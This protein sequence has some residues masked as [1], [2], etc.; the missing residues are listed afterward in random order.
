MTTDTPSAAPAPQRLSPRDEA[1]LAFA[2][3]A[4]LL[5]A[6]ADR[7]IPVRPF[8][9]GDLLRQ[10]LDLVRRAERL[11]E[12][13]V[14][15]EREA[16]T[17]WEQI[18]GVTG[19]TRQAAHERWTADLHAWAT[20]GRAAFPHTADA[21]LRHAEDLDRAYAQRHPDEPRAVT[22][23]L[24]SIRF[25]SHQASEESLRARGAA[26]HAR[27]AELRR[28][29]RDAAP[30]YDRLKHAS[31][32][33]GLLQLAANREDAAAREEQAAA[34]YDALVTAEPALAEEHRT[35]ADRYRADA[36]E[37]R[38]YAADARRWAERASA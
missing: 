24:D 13:A 28:A 4:D 12:R 7:A 18:G 3:S 20:L 30:E 31:D 5:A 33:D 21:S 32:R 14:V 35:S 19:T 25:P 29:D 11:I 1:R 23:G 38:G 17:T 16:G 34:L 2:T 15:A 9:A 26:L 10:A 8:P 27:L 6:A 22:S 37:N 36:E